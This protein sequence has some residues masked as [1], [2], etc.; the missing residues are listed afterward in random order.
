MAFFI[1]DFSSPGI[2][3]TESKEL[4]EGFKDFEGCLVIQTTT[5]M[6]WKDGKEYPINC[7]E[8]KTKQTEGN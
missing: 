3:R 5:P 6:F 8:L 1:V 2:Y 7:R 4:A